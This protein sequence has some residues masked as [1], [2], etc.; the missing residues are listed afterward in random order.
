MYRLGLAL[1][2]A[3][4]TLL[5]AC[6]RPTELA[7]RGDEIVVCGRMFHTGAP[8]VLWMDPGGYDAYRTEKRF[9]PWDKAAYA[10]AKGSEGIT[11]PNRYGVRFVPEAGGAPPATKDGEPS[12][13]TPDEFERIRGGGWDLPLLQQKV[14]QFVLHYDV[15]GTSRQC[16]RTLHDIRGLSVHFMLDL[17]GTIYQTMDVK[18]RA[19]QATIAND[20]SVGVEIA[21]IG[22][23]PDDGSPNPLARWYSTDESGI[24]PQTRITLPPSLG[25]GGIRTPGIIGRPARALPV[26]G[27]VQGKQYR[28]YDFTP[29]QYASLIRLA[30]CLHTVLP[31]IDLDYPRD[32]QGRL[33]THVLSRD[34][35]ERFHGVLG[36]YHIQQNKID[37]GPAMQWDL[38]INGARRLC[39]LPPLPR[40][41]PES[42]REQ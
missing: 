18:E 39:S 6:G 26:V 7:R 15:A 34:E 2:L 10:P 20:R 1:I 41:S 28:Q 4:T 24:A 32:D 3:M 38:L 29:E 42:R 9:V 13:L 31:Q 23:F 8:V 37:P 12:R 14:D 30:A 35:W 22:A 16:F 27:E 19:W 33:V 5:G 36:H 17:D 21:N 25:D 40:G 11:S